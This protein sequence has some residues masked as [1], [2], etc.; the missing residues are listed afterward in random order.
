MSQQ[1]WHKQK[2]T[3][4]P[5]NKFSVIT[6]YAVSA[7]FLLHSTLWPLAAS[8]VQCK[9]CIMGKQ[10]SDVKT[11]DWKAPGGQV[12]RTQKFIF[13]FKI[14]FFSATPAI[15]YNRLPRAASTSTFKVPMRC[16]WETDLNQ[17]GI[18]GGQIRGSRLRLMTSL[19]WCPAWQLKAQIWWS[20]MV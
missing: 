10:L 12:M 20:H 14:F 6:V 13:S 16:G 18:Y 17:C 4:C 7:C 5:M 2:N 9:K 1:T 8:Y 11:W 15:I 19:V 3:K